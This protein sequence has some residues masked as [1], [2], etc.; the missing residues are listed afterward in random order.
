MHTIVKSFPVA[1]KLSTNFS[2]TIC[3][4]QKLNNGDS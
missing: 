3:A 2:K 1:S 4:E